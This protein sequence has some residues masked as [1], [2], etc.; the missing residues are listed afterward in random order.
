VGLCAAANSLFVAPQHYWGVRMPKRIESGRGAVQRPVGRWRLVMSAWLAAV[1]FVV[2]FAGYQALASRHGISPRAASLAGLSS[3]GTIP[4][5][6]DRTRWRRRTGRSG[7]R[8]RPIPSGNPFCNRQTATVRSEPG[9]SMTLSNAAA[10][11][12]RLIVWCLD[13]RH[14]DEPDPAEMVERYGAVCASRTGTPR[15][16][17][18]RVDAAF[19]GAIRTSE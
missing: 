16:L 14:Q 12:V 9:P 6:S 13:R 19:R 1:I 4:A 17:C 3:P 10:A 8:P 7:P 11:H 2:L 15:R 18:S 5:F